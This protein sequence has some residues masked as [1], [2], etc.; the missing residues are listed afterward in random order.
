MHKKGNKF[1]L[2]VSIIL[3]LLAVV[4]I[5]GIFISPL[6]PDAVR[7]SIP[8]KDNTVEF[9]A[10]V[11]DILCL[12]DDSKSPVLI[13]TEQYGNKLILSE[14]NY[15]DMN[16]LNSLTP[17]DIIL[18]SIY[19]VDVAALTNPDSVINVDVLSLSCNG[20]DILSMSSIAHDREILSRENIRNSRILF[21]T[22]ALCFAI[23]AIWLYHKYRKSIKYSANSESNDTADGIK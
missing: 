14:T 18:F 4:A 22:E 10:T 23:A 2:A 9:S 7:A 6:M 16:K 15:I 1:F 12:S 20:Y 3:A 5:V 19:D 8:T 21:I 17:D 11:T 13:E